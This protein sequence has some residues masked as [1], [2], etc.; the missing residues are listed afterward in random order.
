MGS[1]I[2]L[3]SHILP[4]LDEGARSTEESVAMA[5]A[6]SSTGFSSIVA[7]PHVITGLYSNKPQAVREV[8]ATVNQVFETEHIPLKLLPGAEYYWDFEF[9]KMMEND[10][11][12]TINN[13]G[14]Y[15]LVE[16]PFLSI[17][18]GIEEVT[19]KMGMKGIKPL[20][21]HPERNGDIIKDYRKALDLERW[22]FYLQVDLLSLCGVHGP[23]VKKT[24]ELLIK[25]NAFHAAAAD[26]HSLA[27]AQEALAGGIQRLK[28]IAGDNGVERLLHTNPLAFI[29]GNLP[30]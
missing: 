1:F 28:K 10:Q 20:L 11:L 3:H 17:P 8:V 26:C 12:L 6:F 14:K 16:F 4:G 30:G 19:F 27:Q 9:F 21:A 22:G 5:R 7:T 25:N 18:R 24:A 23:D 15:V 2:D 29:E 13:N